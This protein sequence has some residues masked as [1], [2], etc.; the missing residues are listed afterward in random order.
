MAKG[1]GVALAWL[2]CW[3]APA[4]AA[5]K[6]HSRAEDRQPRPGVWGESKEKEFKANFKLVDKLAKDTN[7]IYQTI[8]R[9]EQRL[10]TITQESAK[11]QAQIESVGAEKQKETQRAGSF[12]DH[13]DR[14]AQQQQQLAQALPGLTEKMTELSQPN[15]EAG[16]AILAAARKKDRIAQLY[17]SLTAL[18]A[19]VS[20]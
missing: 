20:K 8:E 4:A 16:R 13:R 19:D 5:I 3:A 7:T 15:E 1:A 10:A 17:R 18:Q 14:T 6:Q 9:E 12:G 2:C 11:L